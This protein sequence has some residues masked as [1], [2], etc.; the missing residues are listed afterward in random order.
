MRGRVRGSPSVHRLPS[1]V[2]PAIFAH[3]ISGCPTDISLV[4]LERHQDLFGVH[5]L[6]AVGYLGIAK[7]QLK[8]SLYLSRF[9]DSDRLLAH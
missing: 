5:A 1:G 7:V 6:P 3:R 2:V 8:T 4:I 9:Q